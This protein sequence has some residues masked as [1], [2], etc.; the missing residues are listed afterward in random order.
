MLNRLVINYRKSNLK[1]NM[2][3]FLY[4]III[5]KR[6]TTTMNKNPTDLFPFYVQCSRSHPTNKDYLFFPME[7]SNSISYELSPSSHSPREREEYASENECIPSF[8][9]SMLG[10]S[11]TIKSLP[12]SVIFSQGRPGVPPLRGKKAREEGRPLYLQQ[13]VL[14]N[15]AA[16]QKVHWIIL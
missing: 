16:R 7:F 14:A 3:Q 4:F 9:H 6:L 5:S 13:T 2:K 1:T 15:Y 8:K 10:A 12:L 11:W